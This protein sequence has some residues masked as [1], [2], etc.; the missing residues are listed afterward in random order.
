[1]DPIRGTACAEQ[2]KQL[3][4]IEELA[5][6]RPVPADEE[7]PPAVARS[8]ASSV[9]QP[10]TLAA[11]PN[12]LFALLG[13]ASPQLKRVLWRQWYEILLDRSSE[14]KREIIQRLVPRLLVR[15]VQDFAGVPGTRVYKSLRTGAIQ[16]PS[17]VLQKPHSGSQR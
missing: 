15:S 2:A 12:R 17:C 6:N 3:R 9:R 13:T 1:L 7:R 4:T 14:R 11:T 5:G 16:Y 8:P 10:R